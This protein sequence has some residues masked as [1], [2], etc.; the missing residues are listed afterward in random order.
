MRNK[1]VM[2]VLS[3][4]KLSGAENIAI[5]IINNLKNFNSYY[6]SPKGSIQKVLLNQS[7]K[8]IG[9]KKFSYLNMLK[10]IYKL[11][12]DIIHSH[13]FTASLF[14]VLIPIRAKKVVHIHQNPL[15]LK[16]PKS[17]KLILFNFTCKHCDAIVFASEQ[18]KNE[19]IYSS[20]FKDKIKIIYNLVDKEYI[21]KKSQLKDEKEYDVLFVGRLVPEKNP[22]LFLKIVKEIDINKKVAI[23]GDGILKHNCLEFIKQ[24]NMNNVELLGFKENPYAYMRKSKINI[25]TSIVEGFGLTIIESILLGNIVLL[26]RIGGF[27]N[28]FRNIE[29]VFCD[30][31]SDYIKKINFYLN[32]MNERNNLQKDLN[33]TVLKYTN[34]SNYIVQWEKV[35]KDCSK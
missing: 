33:K 25:S 21:L 7:I 2:H 16:N 5:T 10:C 4:N 3:T 30:N 22:I 28:V 26:P 32:E 1:K 23:I 31:I 13:D 34:K 18:I 12:P 27:L 17:L 20:R 11:K 14:S 15:W 35:Y 29:E 8:F 19:F 9:M 24:N 6:C